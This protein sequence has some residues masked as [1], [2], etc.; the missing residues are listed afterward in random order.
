[1]T[2]RAAFM[3]HH[4]NQ[5]STLAMH[6]PAARRMAPA[7]LLAALL[8]TLGSVAARPDRCVQVPVAAPGGRLA[9]TRDQQVPDRCTTACFALPPRFMHNHTN[10]P[11]A[12]RKLL[13]SNGQ[14]ATETQRR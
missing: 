8:L 1:M 11:S 13:I 10:T 4:L 2:S 7:S 5:S 14:D 3:R 12:C 9:G 6:V